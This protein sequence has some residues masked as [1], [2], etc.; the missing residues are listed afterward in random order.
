MTR[1]VVATLASLMLASAAWGLDEP[2]DKPGPAPPA[3]SD[4]VAEKVK[5]LQQEMQK[6]RTEALAKL[7]KAENAE[8]RQRLQREYL[9]V[10]HTFAQQFLDLAEQHPNDP[11]AGDAVVA[12]LTNASPGS[13][14][15]TKAADLIVKHQLYPPAV[16]AVLP[17]LVRSDVPGVEQLLRGA[18]EHAKAK[19]D[20]GKATFALAQYVKNRADRATGADA[21]KFE[22]EAENLFETVADKYADV[23]YG[24]GSTLG[25][26]AK[27][28]LFEMKYLSIGKTAPD[29]V[30]EDVDGVKFKLSDYR[31]KVVMLDFWGDW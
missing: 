20:R 29:I 4:S 22:A 26:Q 28:Q 6:A 9:A 18:A 12:A 1:R 10:V 21:A 25:A 19:D 24:R 17:R 13:P 16:V 15:V 23:A 11:A 5:D 30:A 14:E 7:R 3:T 27:P 31:G 2:K 8:D